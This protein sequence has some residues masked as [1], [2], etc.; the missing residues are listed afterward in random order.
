MTSLRNDEPA[1][2]RGALSP[3]QLRIADWLHKQIGPGPAAFFR[4]ACGLLRD[5]ESLSSV[6]HVVAHLLRE[7]ESAV[8]SVLEPGGTGRG[9]STGKHRAK[10]LVVLDQLGISHQDAVAELWLGLAGEDNPLNLARRAHRSG[11]DA[12]RPDGRDFREFFDGVEQILDTVLERFETHYFRVFQGLDDLLT[13]TAP[14]NADADVLRQKFP[15][16]QMVFHYF[17]SRASAAWLGPLRHAGFFVVALEPRV[18]EDAGMVEIPA[19]PESEYLARVAADTPEAAVEA[20]EGIHETDNSR[21]NHDIT[22]VALAAPADVGV[23]LVPQVISSLGG[24]F[25]VL[26][27]QTIG[28]LIVHLTRGG[29]HDDALKL[30]AALLNRMPAP[31]DS[32]S[33]VVAY[34]YVEILRDHLPVLVDAAGMPA[35]TLLCDLLDNLVRGDAERRGRLPGHDGSLTWRRNISGDDDQLSDSDLRHT[36][37]SAV[38][39]AA[40]ALVE[41]QPADLGPV[42]AELESH[43]WLIFRRL[44][45]DLLSS[46]A[47]TARELVV[48]RLTDTAVVRDSG[49]GREYL[50]LAHRGIAC[51]DDH[52]RSRLLV[53]IGAGPAPEESATG[54]PDDKTRGR[55]VWPPDRVAQ[56]TRDRLDAIRD[57]L[58]PEW[59]ARYQALVAEYGP[60]PDPFEPIIT[61]WVWAR[62]EPDGPVSADELA[63]MPTDALVEFLRTWQPSADGWPPLS[64]AS[65]RGAL[66]AAVQNDAVARAADAA[67]FIG[68]P[69]VYVS[70]VLN[71]LWQAVSSDVVL[72]WSGV[73]RLCE[74][75][76]EQA[77]DE[78]DRGEIGEVRQWRGPR[79]DMIRLVMEGLNSRPNSIPQEHAVVVWS[80]IESCC[81]DPEPT[82]GDEAGDAHR[83]RDGFLPLAEQA[84]RPQAIRAAI[85]YGLW[86]RRASSDADL[87]RIHVV[88]E[89]HCDQWQDPSLA[90]RFIYGQLF[91]NLVWMDAD[92]TRTHVQSIFPLDPTQQM[93]L[94]AAWD[95][96]LSSGNLTPGTWELL[97]YV[98]DAMVNRLAA[99]GNS[100]NETFLV[101]QLGVH[102]L[103][104][105]WNGTLRLDSHDTLLKRYYSHV[106]PEIAT[107]LMR[108]LGIG[109]ADQKDPDLDLITQLTTFWEYRVTILRTADPD[110]RGELAE[111]GRW[112]ASGHLPP[113][114]SLQQ[115]LVTLTLA[116]RL[117]NSSVVLSKLADLAPQHPQL[118]LTALTR[119]IS[120]APLE[121]R[122]RRS[123]LSIRTIVE[124]GL[125]AGATE[126]EMATKV[127]SVLARDHGMHLRDLLPPPD[128]AP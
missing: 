103:R 34:D 114:W 22:R 10:V 107:D 33:R 95:G 78:L 47:D 105:L 39:D 8:R 110:T 61:S 108:S 60:A 67:S 70:A 12:P 102:L 27:P 112:F 85:R 82:P 13:R 2:H 19:W 28:Q 80:L 86:L 65:L 69:A 122:L 1:R 51:L 66:S 93:L 71:G 55:E 46:Y 32:T 17:F 62:G 113:V 101:T 56:W 88:L 14:S 77:V 68:L 104:N 64:P 3:R 36:L 45:L 123:E 125:T 126:T 115:L 75:I 43:D 106:S 84:V 83:V 23:R 118:S 31:F 63:A 94:L 128:P 4:D 50:Q 24:R 48:D 6:T 97:T 54:A 76:N 121:W 25:G 96:Y 57:V 87:S 7:V 9:F 90:V 26:I 98:Y 81:Q 79:G 40:T 11:L 18:D 120:S 74:W 100:D 92:W 41:A 58:P 44:A 73:L 72:E 91:A 29:Q 49:V 37:V 117:E 99:Q 16:N 38:R 116:G 21:V 53:L 15:K 59:D 119:W 30:A 111:F 5:G 52:A 127:I 42:V 20:A 124:T 89:Q 109:L 35:L